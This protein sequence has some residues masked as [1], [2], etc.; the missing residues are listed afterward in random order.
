[1]DRQEREDVI[2]KVE[3]HLRKMTRKLIK[4][5]SEEEALR[6]LSDTF[7]MQ[8][9]SDFVSV[10]FIENDQY[11][12]KVWSGED[13]G[14]SHY[15]PLSKDDCHEQVIKK[16]LTNF[17]FEKNNVQCKLYYI[18]L[19]NG[20]NTWFTV[21]IYNEV[22]P[23]GFCLVGFFDY[24]KLLAMSKHFDEFG[25]DLALAI[26]LT[27]EREAEVKKTEGI[28]WITHSLSIDSPL[29]VT[30]KE[31]T[32]SAAK[33][34]NAEFACIY[35]Y[36]DIDD[37]FIY[38]PP[39]Y[40]EIPIKQEISVEDTNDLELI[41]P[42]LDRPGGH[43]L[44]TL[45]VMDI[46]MI[47]ILHVK[48]KAYGMFNKEDL[49]T[50]Q[51]LSNHMATNLE[52]VRLYN[53]EKEHRHRLHFLLE[54]QQS[55]VKETIKQDNFDGITTMINQLFNEPIVLFD[56]FMRPISYKL[57]DIDEKKC[58]DEIKEKTLKR[59]QSSVNFISLSK[60]ELTFS[61]WPIKS[62]VDLLGY[63]AIGMSKSKLDEYDQ[64]MI[65]MVRNI[66]S[67]QFSKQKLVFDTTEQAKES[68]ANKLFQRQITEEDK[69][70]VLQY[71]N[72]FMW[73]VYEPH[74]VIL[75]SINFDEEEKENV[76]LLEIQMKK[77]RVWD[78][79]KFLVVDKNDDILATMLND[80]FL[81]IVPAFNVDDPFW[82]SL[83]SSLKEASIKSKVK[84]DIY[85]GIGSA[86][87]KMEDYYI[88]SEQARRA[89]NVVMQGYRSKTYA[90]F[91][92]LGSY[93]ILQYLLEKNVTNLFIQQQLGTL[94][95]YSKDNNMNLLETLRTYLDMNGNAK[96]T[97][98]AL[99]LHR[100][101]LLYRLDKIEELLQIELDDPEARFNLMLAYKLYDMK[102]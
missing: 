4:I 50:L 2:R 90:F 19:E 73:D 53:N 1:M 23:F 58:I 18:L 49:K 101:S 40:G 65:E 71:A 97:A 99:F 26:M 14:I 44:T 7:R 102:D 39:S 82:E 8:L 41:F 89:L 57:N 21:P 34:T 67:I 27:R 29:D 37:C 81:L 46:K 11:I 31:I 6:Y 33:G 60:I 100:S 79:V 42:Y 70:S 24:V 22:Q 68:F 75:I 85:F 80:Y 45:I 32:T 83:Y 95:S 55:L 12:P 96:A 86:T 3:H 62:G 94:I 20:V 91:E 74:R 66:Y 64:L 15:F 35:L 38:Q 10:I 13:R 47:G 78:Y 36:N 17:E 54:Y 69:E 84:C 25:K 52:N 92:S 63:L 30:I 72:L 77:E 51:F 87:E 76:N 93:T 59:R 43:E 88:S 56:R 16:S 28:E 5:D 98:E 9:Y 48:N 61:L